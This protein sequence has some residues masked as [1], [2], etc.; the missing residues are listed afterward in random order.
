MFPTK[1]R[2]SGFSSGSTNRRK[3]GSSRPTMPRNAAI[4]TDYMEAYED[5][6]RNTATAEAP[7]Y[8]VPADNK[9]FTCLVVSEAII[10]ALEGMDLRYPE[11]DASKQKELKKV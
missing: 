2:K 8:V 3:T 9:W 11:V 1:S 4:G 6:I 7:W 10:E 5:M